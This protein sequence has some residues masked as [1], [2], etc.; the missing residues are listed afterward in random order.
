MKKTFALIAFLGAMA[1]TSAQTITFDHTIL[2]YGNIPHN[3]DGNRIFKVKN[4]GNKPLI[5][6]SIKTSC[7]C[8]TPEYSKDPIAPGKTGHIKVHYNT[9]TLGEFRKLIEVFSND[10]ENSRAVLYIKGNVMPS[11]AQSTRATPKAIKK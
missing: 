10:P 3:A 5:I 2:D 8:T 1:F 11:D 9:A 6:S 7:G 4:T